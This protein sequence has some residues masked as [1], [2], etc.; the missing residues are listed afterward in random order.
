MEENSYSNEIWEHVGE[1]CF[2]PLTSYIRSNPYCDWY[3]V[4]SEE[5]KKK[6]KKLQDGRV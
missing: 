5:A 3:V 4:P 6:L 2:E 1:I